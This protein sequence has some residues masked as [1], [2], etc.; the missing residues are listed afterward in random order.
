[1]RFSRSQVWSVNVDQQSSPRF[2]TRMTSYA[3]PVTELYSGPGS[4]VAQ[5]SGYQA[6]VIDGLNFGPAGTLIDYATYG[7]GNGTELVSPGCFL[8]VPQTQVTCNT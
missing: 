5:T 4:H 6:V 1:M 2:L 3:P 7:P 8:S